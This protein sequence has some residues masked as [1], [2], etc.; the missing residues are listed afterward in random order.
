MVLNN[1]YREYAVQAATGLRQQAYVDSD[2]TY[3][4]HYYCTAK[5]PNAK[6]ADKVW[7]V[8][9]VREVTATG[10]FFD[11]V[12]PLNGGES[13]SEFCFHAT[14]LAIVSALIYNDA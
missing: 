1:S 9:R 6:L 5:N 10:E 11:M 14:D 13:T 3:T 12:F 4:I 7:R 2:A 8:S